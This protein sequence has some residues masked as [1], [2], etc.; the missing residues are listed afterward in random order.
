M[1]AISGILFSAVLGVTFGV[2][3]PKAGGQGAVGGETRFFRVVGPGSTTIQGIAAD[4]TVVWTNTMTGVTCTVQTAWSLASPTNW[5][6]YLQV[7]VTNSIT[8]HRLCNPKPPAGMVLI[9][10][11]VFTMGDNLDGDT[12]AR[13]HTVYVSAFYMDQYLVTKALWEDVYN[14]ATNHGYSFDNAGASKAANHPVQTVN[15]YDCVKWCN[16]RSEKEG[17]TPAYYTDSAQTA[18]YR[19]GQVD[20]DNS[21]VKWNTGYRLPTEAEWEKAARGGLKGKRFPWG[22]TV[23]HSQ[24]NYFS[25][26]TVIYDTS[27][28][29]GFHPN[30]YDEVKPYTSPVGSFA[31]NGYGLYDMAGNVWERCWDGYLVYYDTVILTDPRGPINTVF[32]V[33]RGSCWNGNASSCRTSARGSYIPEFA[34]NILG[35]RSVI[36]SSQP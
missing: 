27:L 22:D 13:P 34:D 19:S 17:R 33:F 11:G 14:W 26:D 24:M 2:A 25:T 9:P 16:A 4:G 3:T 32:K 7:P 28:T 6:D 23:A 35:F 12:T 8:S 15:W 20:V 36:P 30:Y 21:W 29:R 10:A 5:V 1:K 18:V 31:P